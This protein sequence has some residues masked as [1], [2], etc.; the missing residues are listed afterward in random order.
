MRKGSSRSRR[1]GLGRTARS[2]QAPSSRRQFSLYHRGQR[3]PSLLRRALRV[4]VL[5]FLTVQ[6]L[7]AFFVQSYAV[8]SEA[9]LPTLE[10][11]DRVLSV[12]LLYG[13]T[14][15]L[16]GRRLPGVSGPQRGELVLVEPPY[17][18][19]PS[20][21]VRLV[22][23]VVRFFS[24]QRLSLH[25]GDEIWRSPVVVKRVLALPGDRIRFED[26]RAQVIPDAGAPEEQ[27]PDAGAP[28]SEFELADRP[29]ELLL[30]GTP[31]LPDPMLPFGGA[32]AEYE[33]GPDEYFVA[34]DNR[35]RSLDSR[36]WGVVSFRRLRARITLRYF[37]FGRFGVL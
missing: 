29:Y 10:S 32:G 34:G 3:P 14:V 7:S 24:A 16:T 17:Y 37:P 1:F 21:A 6:V 15:P 5:L 31:E 27:A 12:P 13:P 4:V 2:A 28:R 20:L 11:G 18:E 9:M 35:A 19:R 22:D 8:R 33:L 25:R 36:H 26:Y 23:P 30:D